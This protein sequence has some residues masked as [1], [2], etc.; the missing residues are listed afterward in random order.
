MTLITG[1]PLEISLEAIMRGEGMDLQAVRSRK[2]AL[3][4]AAER[5]LVE[6]LPL[7][8]PAAILREVGVKEHRHNRILLENGE[9]LTGPLVAD[10]LG[11]AQRLV[12]VV[13]T[14]GPA[15]ETEVSRLLNEDP[16]YALA[17][18]GL[19][20]AAVE[21]LSQE[22]CSHIGGQILTSGQTA[23]TP[24]SPGIPDWPVEIGQREIF[25]L[26]NPS[27]AGIRLTTGGM[28]VPKKSVSFVVGIGP[29]MSQT[30]L[31]LI[32]SL[33]ETCRYQHA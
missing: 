12:A 31:C 5:A 26:L 6:G 25:S 13:C 24:L 16:P 14:I 18:D 11:G 28:M 9:A 27:K 1:W 20:N 3:V 7:I 15:L 19:G 8:H 32:C 17:L 2:P 23:S 21:T 22:I 4:A 33:K 30:G 10:H 29:A